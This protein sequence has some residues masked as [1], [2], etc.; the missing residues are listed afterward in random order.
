MSDDQR[1]S[2]R[3]RLTPTFDVEN[4]EKAVDQA[5]FDEG[6]PCVM[7]TGIRKDLVPSLV[8]VSFLYIL[9]MRFFRY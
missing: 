8:E 3:A 6:K 5:V 4:Q 1:P 2:K 9:A 7:I